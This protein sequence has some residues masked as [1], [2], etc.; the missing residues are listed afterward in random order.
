LSG[1]KVVLLEMDLRKPK[2]SQHLGLDNALGFSTYI[3]GQISLEKIIVSSGVQDNLY[4]VPS[5]PVPPNPA[6]VLI[7]HSVM[8]FFK[9]LRQNFDYIIIDA[10]PV[11]LVT[12]A[13]IL[14]AHSDLNIY[15]VRQ[16]YTFKD[17]LNI[18]KK[19]VE[20]QKM[21]R[22]SFIVNDINAGTG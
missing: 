20:E 15:L 16:G 3:T 10:A 9:V 19:L 4:V 21:P 13:Q 1:K 8:D 14:A 11:G 5:G 6:E 18:P 7:K 17:Q 12:D 2:I 22:L